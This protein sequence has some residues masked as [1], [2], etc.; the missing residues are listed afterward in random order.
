MSIDENQR[1]SLP[2]S[3]PQN[4]DF[5]GRDLTDNVLT[6]QEFYQANFQQIIGLRTHFRQNQFKKCTF[7][8]A[9]VRSA[10]W[11]KCDLTESIGKISDF[12][13]SIFID[14][15]FSH[16]VFSGSSFYGATF[17]NCDL[18][19]SNFGNADLRKV[20]FQDSRIIGR[21]KIA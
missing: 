14:C 1:D 19:N 13:D 6:L 7:H 5:R 8:A 16:T 17:V 18:S 15:N 10:K 20:K 12:E 3:Q 2:S 11:E 4:T 9:R 21:K